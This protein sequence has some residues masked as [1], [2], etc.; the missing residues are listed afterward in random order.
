[1]GL[2]NQKLN[3]DYVEQLF[4][5][6]DLGESVLSLIQSGRLSIKAAHQLAGFSREDVSACLS[7]FKNV[8]A[9]KNIQLQLLTWLKEIAA[10]D[11][12]NVRTAFKRLDLDQI[13]SDDGF[14]N[15]VKLRHLRNCLFDHRFPEMSK[16][17]NSIKDKI[18]ALKLGQGIRFIPPENFERSEYEI[19]FTIKHP[20]EFKSIVSSLD[21]LCRN[22]SIK[23]ILSP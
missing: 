14:D 23:Q 10:R 5:I 13:L 11:K 17:R 1:M 20:E 3:P 4:Y 16:T 22:D 2:L 8:R 15:A 12:V 7:V 9:S 18:A 6:A 19:S 21:T